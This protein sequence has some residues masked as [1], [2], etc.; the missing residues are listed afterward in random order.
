MNNLA[1]NNP[2]RTGSADRLKIANL[3]FFAQTPSSPGDRYERLSASM[4]EA[5]TGRDVAALSEAANAIAPSASIAR[6]AW[7]GISFTTPSGYFVSVL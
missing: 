2:G 7:N 4:I 6:C 1:S 5:T 3:A